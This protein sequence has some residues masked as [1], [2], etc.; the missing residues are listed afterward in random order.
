MET[1]GQKTKHYQLLTTFKMKAIQA[2]FYKDI[3]VIALI[4]LILYSPAISDW[5]IILAVI[6]LGGRYSDEPT[7]KTRS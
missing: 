2:N 6:I 1:L 5:W 3:A 7:K 4:A